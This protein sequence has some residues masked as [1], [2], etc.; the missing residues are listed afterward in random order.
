MLIIEGIDEVPASASLTRGVVV[1]QDRATTAFNRVITIPDGYY[2]FT[3]S[4]SG[5]SFG[6]WEPINESVHG[7]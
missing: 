1:S 2:E 3:E 5:T 7:N 4:E 6:V